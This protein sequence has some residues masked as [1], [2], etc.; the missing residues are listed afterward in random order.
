MTAPSAVG[1]YG[2]ATVPAPRP[3]AELLQPVAD[4]R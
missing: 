3:A 4:Q 2:T 1:M